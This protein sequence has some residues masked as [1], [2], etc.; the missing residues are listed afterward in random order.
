MDS[1]TREVLLFLLEREFSREASHWRATGI[2]LKRLQQRVESQVPSPY[3]IET[4]TTRDG[5]CIVV[6]RKGDDGVT[7]MVG[8]I[9]DEGNKRV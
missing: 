7:T 3:V 2:T 9:W 5:T 1:L 6:M 8:E 4:D